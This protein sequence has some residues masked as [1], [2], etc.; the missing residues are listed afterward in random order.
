MHPSLKPQHQ[1]IASQQTIPPRVTLAAPVATI[2][3]NVKPPT[4]S[5]GITL[6]FLGSVA[7]DAPGY[8]VATL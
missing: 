8:E 7:T 3:Q 1:S 5:A 4:S 2:M 6:D